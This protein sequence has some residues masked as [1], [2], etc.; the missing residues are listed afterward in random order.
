MP[1]A[2][3]QMRVVLCVRTLTVIASPCAV[4]ASQP[5]S[6]SLHRNYEQGTSSPYVAFTTSVLAVHVLLL[7]K[8][9]FSYDTWV[10]PG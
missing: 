3:L 6:T 5:F 2:L 7:P 1:G 9:H 8:V 4:S 10:V